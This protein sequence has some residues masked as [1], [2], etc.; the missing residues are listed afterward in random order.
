MSEFVLKHVCKIKSELVL[1]RSNA[2]IVSLFTIFDTATDINT[3][4]RLFFSHNNFN[5]T[6][7]YDYPCE[8]ILGVVFILTLLS[9]VILQ[10]NYIFKRLPHPQNKFYSVI[11][12]FFISPLA[13]SY[14]IWDKQTILQN[15][16]YTILFHT[17]WIETVHESSPA[18]VLQI[19]ILLVISYDHNI[20]KWDIL[21]IFTIIISILSSLA[22][23][24]N[25][26]RRYISY[27]NKNKKP[28]IYYFSLALFASSD[29][30][31]RCLILSLYVFVIFEFNLYN[32]YIVSVI[33]LLVL[34]QLLFYVINLDRDSKTGLDDKKY[35]VV[36]YIS[37]NKFFYILFIIFHTIIP[38]CIIFLRNFHI[39]NAK[40]SYN[41]VF[42]NEI[43][44][45]VLLIYF[46]LH[47]YIKNKD[48]ISLYIVNF[49][50]FIVYLT[51]INIL[52]FLVLIYYRDKI[53]KA[54]ANYTEDSNASNKSKRMRFL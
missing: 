28:I 11:S 17:I 32:I 46:W 51:F 12:L 33:L 7:F 48:F 24:G 49:Y 2:I 37:R 1:R 26:L 10:F 41:L 23:V 6:C 13:M 5:S 34:H 39:L 25:G 40:L 9:C 47:Q 30:L 4:L 44:I 21:T 27:C 20:S 43:T 42:I 50:L 36:Y 18:A 15:E 8:L 52:P 19:V 16:S 29:L 3:I 22:S 31:N 54:N 45:V 35:S 38:S 53:N 14:F